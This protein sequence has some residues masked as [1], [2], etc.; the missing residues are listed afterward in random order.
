[1]EWNDDPERQLSEV[2]DAF[3]R[4]INIAHQERGAQLIDSAH[5]PVPELVPA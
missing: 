5:Q 1:M 4:A 2:L 3:D